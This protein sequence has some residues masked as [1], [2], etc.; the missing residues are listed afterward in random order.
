MEGEGGSGPS[1]EQFGARV[2]QVQVGEEPF[3]ERG[4]VCGESGVDGVGGGAGGGV[5]QAG[6]WAAASP[7]SAHHWTAATGSAFEDPVEAPGAHPGVGSSTLALDFVR[8]AAAR[9]DIPTAYLL[10][11]DPAEAVTQRLIS[12]EARIRLAG[13]QLH[14]SRFAAGLGAHGHRAS[15]PAVS[16]AVR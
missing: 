13:A 2:G 11:D 4:Q 5:E 16:L 7:T 12:A 10:L 6:S 1:V 8:G 9:H 14:Y 15:R 3:G